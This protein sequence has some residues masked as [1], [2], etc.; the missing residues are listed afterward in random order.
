MAIFSRRILQQLVDE[1]AKFLKTRHTKKI[2]SHLNRMHEELTLAPEWEVVIIN[3]LSKIGNVDYERN[4]GGRRN[5][6][7]CFTPFSEP[8]QSFAV[9]ITTLSDKG[10][11]AKNPIEELQS[12]VIDRVASRGLRLNGFHFKVGGTDGQKYRRYH[13]LTKTGN[14]SKPFFEGGKKI[15]LKL[16]GPSRFADKILNAQFDTFLDKIEKAPLA[17]RDY[18]VNNRTENIDVI[19]SYRPHEPYSLT[20]HPG[21]KNIAHITENQ[22]YDALEDKANQLVE[23]HFEDRLGI[24]LCDGDYSPFHHDRTSVDEVIK[25]FLERRSE[26]NFV[27]TLKVKR[28][29][30]QE[31]ID[32]NLYR[33]QY[34]DL[35]GSELVNSLHRMVQLLPTPET[36]TCNAFYHLKSGYPQEGDR[37][38]MATI[39]RTNSIELR[40]PTRMLMELLAGRLSHSDFSNLQGYE[41]FQDHPKLSEN[42]FALCL[43]K[44]WMISGIKFES[45][46]P[47][48]DNDFI[49][50]SIDTRPD[51]AIHRFSTPSSQQQGKK[52]T[53][54]QG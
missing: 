48:E 52:S 20:N 18:V 34:F 23:S 53:D 49:I 36:D 24:I 28:Q 21:Y 15:E 32:A 1:N 46:A 38:G 25:V 29:R 33:G 31:T 3:T 47:H 22:I 42:P 11:D 12:Q 27:L 4:F 13:R 26:I 5:P 40:I 51:A 16:P 41:S 45:N 30:G 54:A 7:I 14:L 50:V 9:D 6:D 19:I 44:G 39:Y 17:D 43:E 2:V 37:K 10:F 8:Q 35:V